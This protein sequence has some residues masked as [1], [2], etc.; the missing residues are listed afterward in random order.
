VDSARFDTL[1]RVLATRRIA[2]TSSLVGG[3]AVLL[4]VS[5]VEEAAAHN[6]I[7]ACRRI[8]DPVKRRRCLR[9]ARAHN[10]KRHSCRPRP[11]AITC[12]NRCGRA[13]DNCRKPVACAC[14]V[15]K[16]CL[17]NNSCASA[18]SAPETCPP[19]CTCLFPAVEGGMYCISLAVSCATVPQVC[20]STVQ[21]PLGQHCMLTGCGVSGPEN[22][23][24]PLC[25]S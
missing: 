16:S 1:T 13:I 5:W 4:G 10:R 7:P 18:C 19:G 2:I 21:C 23:C 3:I 25:P 24:V 12:V 8:A 15:G 6:P 9:R 11:V 22:R 20:T 14:P 17:L